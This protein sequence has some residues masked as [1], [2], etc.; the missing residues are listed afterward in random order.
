ML[1]EH[2]NVHINCK[3][4]NGRTALMWAAEQ[5]NEGILA[6][7]LKEDID[8]NL[9]DKDGH[10]ALMLAAELGHVD[11]VTQLLA[12]LAFETRYTKVVR[13]K[14]AFTT[15]PPPGFF[16]YGILAFKP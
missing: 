5:G 15:A 2:P 12:A 11:V 7:L 4:I 13:L 14:R 3:D 1:L 8:I 6:M 16:I 9:R 10:N